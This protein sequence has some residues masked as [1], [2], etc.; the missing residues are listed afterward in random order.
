CSSIDEE[1][2]GC[3]WVNRRRTQGKS[4]GGCPCKIYAKGID[5]AGAGPAGFFWCASLGDQEHPD[6]YAVN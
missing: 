6:V 1:A 4:V 5:F 3:S 2:S